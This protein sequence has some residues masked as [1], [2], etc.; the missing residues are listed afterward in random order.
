MKGLWYQTICLFCIKLSITEQ[1]L[2]K[3]NYGS[4]GGTKISHNSAH[5]SRMEKRFSVF[6]PS[7][8][9]RSDDVSL[10][11][12]VKKTNNFSLFW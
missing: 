1:L 8:D 3:K 2:F 10:T 9:A 12:K 11:Q 7:S 5:T 6:Y 4:G